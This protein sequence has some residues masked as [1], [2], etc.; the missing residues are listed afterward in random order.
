[1]SL[2]GV[3]SNWVLLAN[4]ATRSLAG[5]RICLG[6]LAAQWQTTTMADTAITTEVHQSLDIHGNRTAQ[7]TFNGVLADR[8][9]NRLDFRLGQILDLYVR[10]DASVLANPARSDAPNAIDGC[11]C[12]RRV[13]VRRYVNSG[14][15]CPLDHLQRNNVKVWREQQGRIAFDRQ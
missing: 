4:R 6:L 9:A 12:N 8:P 1:M 5:T 14:D 7:V 15:T 3:L 11:Q 2:P 13:L 10:L